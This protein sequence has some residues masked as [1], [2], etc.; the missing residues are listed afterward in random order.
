MTLFMIWHILCVCV[1]VCVLVSL[2]VCS[3]VRHIHHVQRVQAALHIAGQKLA[4]S[5]ATTINILMANACVCVCARIQQALIAEH[6][7]TRWT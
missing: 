3:H 6:A 1:C 5:A 2:C 4:G 7:K